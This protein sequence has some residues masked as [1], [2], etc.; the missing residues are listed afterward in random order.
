AGLVAIADS[1]RDA[2]RTTRGKRVTILLENTA[3]QGTNLGFRFEHL[4]T[5]LRNVRSK[6]LG[7]CIDTCHLFASG[8]DVRSG[9]AYEAVMAEL[10]ETVGIE[11]VRALHLNDSKHPLGS[12]RDRH[13]HIGAG[14]IG[15]AAFRRLVND[16]RFAGKPGLLETPGGIDGY[17]E[18]LARLRRMRK[19]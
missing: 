18:N 17:E 19:S 9:K 16:D 3:G 15:A 4:A 13:E 10:D 1:L 2:L 14:E 7:V 6:R 5:L 11:R 8:Y 12:R